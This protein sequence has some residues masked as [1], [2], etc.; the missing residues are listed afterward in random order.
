MSHWKQ[1]R[2]VAAW[3]FARYFKWRDQVLGLLLFV[4][5]SALAWGVGKFASGGRRAMT[6]AT[7]GIELT[8][9]PG[10]RLRFVEAP[11]DSA[12]QATLLS[13]GDAGGILTRSMD[14]TF[15]LKVEKDPR[16]LP[17]LRTLIAD[18]VRQERL[19]ASGL[20]ESQ[21]VQIL[22]PPELN[23]RFTDPDRQ[24]S[25]RAE[26]IAAT[27][28]LGLV[29]LSVFTSMAYLLTGITGEKQLRVTES[30]T[31]IIPPQAWIDGKI[32]GIGA[33]AMANIL[34][35][36]AGGIVLAV[37]A[38]VTWG[39]TIPDII[40]RPGVIA[41]LVVFS[42]LALL[43]WNSAFAAFASTI[44]DPNTSAR[45]SMMFLPFLPVAMTVSV[46]RDPDHI[47]SR[48]LA[49]FPLTSPSA[50]PIR[51]IL[52][53]PGAVEIAAAVAILVGTIW[54]F[55]R[56]AGRIFEIGMLMYGK[57]PS[58]REMWRWASARGVPPA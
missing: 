32:L 52:S 34:N 38:R 11:A 12:G 31:A 5:L 15:E 48:V 37:V 50:M 25:G 2:L 3:E 40:V 21:L 16:Y 23:V 7:S 17:E 39:F 51:V 58:L 10:S 46:L 35:M 6:V 30:I 22:A 8:P 18:V 28:F 55:R 44:D 29:M 57:E 26:R 1:V 45:T 20:A 47:A 43:L 19:S 54:L 27:I 13:G 14:G 42:V 24:R 4:G 36:V 49:L 9:R 56:L 33:Y 53:N 41:V